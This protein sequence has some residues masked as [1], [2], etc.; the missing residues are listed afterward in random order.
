MIPWSCIILKVCRVRHAC[1]ARVSVCWEDF[2]EGLARCRGMR[3]GGW[4]KRLVAHDAVVVHHP[5]D[6]R[7][8]RWSMLCERASV[9]A[10][11]VASSRAVFVA[12]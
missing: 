9:C 5:G 3:G 4:M 10:R 2:E 7:V 1:I 6:S 8:S 11:T 12:R